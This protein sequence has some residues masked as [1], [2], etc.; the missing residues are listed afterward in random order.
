MLSNENLDISVLFEEDGQR[1]GVRVAAN[2]DGTSAGELRHM[3]M[4]Q[5]FGR[6]VQ[7]AWSDMD[8]EPIPPASRMP[9]RV[10]RQFEI[11][12]AGATRRNIRIGP[13]PMLQSGHRGVLQLTLLLTP[14]SNLMHSHRGTAGG[15][16]G[17]WPRRAQGI[18]GAGAGAGAGP[19]RHDGPAGGGAGRRDLF[20][21]SLWRADAGRSVCIAD[22]LKCQHALHREAAMFL[23]CRRMRSA[24]QRTCWSS[25]MS[26]A[27]AA[28]PAATG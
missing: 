24:S 8:G 15:C 17:L 26:A 5:G 6:A 13:V 21:M 19:V 18:A 22:R 16:Q 12:D 2:D 23:R 28:L 25:C 7:V 1:S 11:C 10:C 3:R 20:L 14:T 27:T 4:I 9:I